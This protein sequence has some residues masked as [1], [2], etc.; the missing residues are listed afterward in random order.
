MRKLILC[1]SCIFFLASCHTQPLI[2]NPKILPTNYVCA[3]KDCIETLKAP[4]F[5]KKLRRFYNIRGTIEFI[6]IHNGIANLVFLVKNHG[7]IVCVLKC[8][9]QKNVKE[10]VEISELTEK[11]RNKG[12]PV[13]KVD[14]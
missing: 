14:I 1:F 12:F 3:A 11:L 7:K 6:S 4:S 8:F 13:P 5:N 2:N 10:V 9:L